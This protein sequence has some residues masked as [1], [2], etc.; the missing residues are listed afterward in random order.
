MVGGYYDYSPTS[1]PTGPISSSYRILRGG[2]WYY[3]AN[4]CRV[5]DRYYSRPDP[6]FSS[7]GFRIVLDF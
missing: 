4:R 2:G 7:Y 6:R 3:D 1:N 5:A